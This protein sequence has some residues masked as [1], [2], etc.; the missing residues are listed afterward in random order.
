[1]GV[2][3]LELLSV[4]SGSTPG[5]S[6]ASVGFAESPPTPPLPLLPPQVPPASGVGAPDEV[7][8][9]RVVEARLLVE[10]AKVDVELAKVDVRVVLE[11]NECD[12]W[13]PLA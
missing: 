10:E 13:V 7:V 3:P 4:L 12:T 8:V 9:N 6:V 5:A 1:M 2:S 11:N